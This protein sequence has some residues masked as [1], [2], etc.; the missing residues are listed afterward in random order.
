MKHVKILKLNKDKTQTEVADCQLIDGMVKCEGE[1]A[2][3]EL[4]ETE[5][6]YQLDSKTPRK[7]FPKDGEVFLIQLKSNF[8][9]SYYGAE[10]IE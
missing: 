10:E 7:V 3:I 9:S 6:I 8:S 1:P 4:F 2:L 5:G